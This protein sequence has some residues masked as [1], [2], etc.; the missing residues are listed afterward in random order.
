MIVAAGWNQWQALP[1]VC[2]GMITF[3]VAAVRLSA[4]VTCHGIDVAVET[5]NGG[6]AV[7]GAGGSSGGAAVERP[8]RR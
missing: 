2:I 6:T 3:G 5:G 1:Q 7:N 4:R 8:L